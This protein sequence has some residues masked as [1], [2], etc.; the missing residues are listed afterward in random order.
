MLLGVQLSFQKDELMHIQTFSME[1]IYFMH[2]ENF[3]K[4]L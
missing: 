2:I 4:S 1:F 3:R